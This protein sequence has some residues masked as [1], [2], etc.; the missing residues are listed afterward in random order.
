M[1]QQNIA[2]YWDMEYHTSS[3][4]ISDLESST[5]TQH[6]WTIVIQAILKNSNAILSLDGQPTLQTVKLS[7][8]HKL[9][10]NAEFTIWPR[11]ARPSLCAYCQEWH[12]WSF[13]NSLFRFLKENHL[14]FWLDPPILISK[15]NTQKYHK[16]VRNDPFTFQPW[17]ITHHEWYS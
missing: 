14:W 5:K 12:N 10:R 2:A 15:K 6:S 13:S 1:Y 17:V 8:S 9:G 11:Q 3:T 16:Q 7:G 4:Q